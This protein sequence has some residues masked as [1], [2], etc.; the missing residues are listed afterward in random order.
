MDATR[1]FNFILREVEQLKHPG[2]DVDRSIRERIVAFNQAD[3][4]LAGEESPAEKLIGE[5]LV[6]VGNLEVR[7]MSSYCVKHSV[8]S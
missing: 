3:Q 7:A 5:K 1:R 2:V 6:L 4:Q 8:V